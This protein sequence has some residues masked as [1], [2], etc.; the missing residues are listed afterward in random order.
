MECSWPAERALQAQLALD[1]TP[2]AESPMRA[3]W[4]HRDLR[5]EASKVKQAL[6]VQ[7]LQAQ[8]QTESTTPITRVRLPIQIV[9]KRA[10][11]VLGPQLRR[12]SSSPVK[13]VRGPLVVLV[14][15]EPQGPREQQAR[16]EPLGLEVVDF[17]PVAQVR[18][19]PAA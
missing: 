12:L 6:W 7:G 8:S 16:L 5:R 14:A 10:Q 18:A 15:L 3:W 2:T 9:P 11:E 1:G 19:A 17:V 4:Q 13:V